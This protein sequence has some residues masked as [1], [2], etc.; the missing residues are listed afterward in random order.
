MGASIR[1]FVGMGLGLSL[2]ATPVLAFD[3][4]DTA[5]GSSFRALED[6]VAH[7]QAPLKPLSDNRLASIE[8]EGFCFGCPSI[9]VRINV[10]PII[11]FGLVNQFNFAFGNNI[12][13]VNNGSV[14]NTIRFSRY[15]F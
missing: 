11:Q 14:G 3:K 13:Q 8:G 7:D 1:F 5:A 10:S 2:V 4:N 15:R 12:S 6:I 9:H